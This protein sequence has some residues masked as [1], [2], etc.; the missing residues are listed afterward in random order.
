MK[1]IA[2]ILFFIVYSSQAEPMKVLIITGGHDFERESFFE[3]FESFDDVQWQEVKHPNA[4]LFY[5][6]N[7]AERFDVFV[8]Y[9]MNQN[10]SRYEKKNLRELAEVGKPMIF[11]HHSLVSYQDWPEFEKII[12][13]KYHQEEKIRGDSLVPASTYQHDVTIEVKIEAP[14]HPV[15]EGMHDFTMKDEVYGG[16][17]YLSDINPLLST[18]HSGSS[19]YIAWVNSYGN[20]KIVYIQPGHDHKAFENLNYRKLLYQALKWSYEVNTKLFN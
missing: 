2:I 18:D 6:S 12:G 16:F 17:T 7:L 11:L 1:Y 19:R 3:M 5:E 8:F 13:G 9:D 20:S 4:N 10:I 14:E 15:L